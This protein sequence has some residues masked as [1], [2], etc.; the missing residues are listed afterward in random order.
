MTLPWEYYYCHDIAMGKSWHTLTHPWL[1]H[2]VPIMVLIVVA[3]VSIPW[4]C[5]GVNEY[6]AM[7]VKPPRRVNGHPCGVPW[8]TPWRCHGIAMTLSLY[9]PLSF[10]APPWQASVP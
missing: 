8:H 3:W 7:E 9:V 5:M 1:S 10:M 6:S 4:Q 2:G